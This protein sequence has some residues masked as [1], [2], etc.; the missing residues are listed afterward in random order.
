M[1][2]AKHPNILAVLAALLVLA[3]PFSSRAQFTFTT[4]NG[5]ITITGYTGSGGNVVIPSTTNGYPVTTIGIGAF[6]GK[7]TVTSVTIPNSVTS[8]GDHA[9]IDC[10]ILTNVTIGNGVSSIGPNAFYG[11]SSLTSVKIPNSV[12]S[13][14]D[15]A[16]A[17][18]S[19]LTS[20]TI[21]TNVN[22]IAAFAFVGCNGLT[23]V[24]IPNSIT[25]MG[26]YAFSDCSGLHQAYFQGNAPTVN[27]GEAGSTDSTIF[28]GES[29]MAYYLPGT[30]GWGS[31]FGGWP[32]AALNPAADFTYITNNGTIT[33]TGY[34][35]SGGNVVIPGTI[36]GYLVTSIDTGAFYNITTITNV[37]IPNSV[38]SIGLEA[39]FTCSSL[40]S[41]TIPDSVASI[42]DDAFGGCSG[43][44]S[45]TLG[46]SVTSI[47][48]GAFD[49]CL[50][51]TSV[52]IPNSVTSIGNAAFDYC[53]GLTSV[54]IPNSVT[55]IGDAPFGGC[56]SLTNIAVDAANP[57]YASVAGVL[58]NK[59][60]TLLIQYP[61]GLAGSYA[62]PNSVSS[63][64]GSAFFNCSSLTS[65]T[66]PNSVTSIGF[67]AF[68]YCSGLAS[69]TVGNSVT[70]IGN[71][72]F[73]SCTSL[74]R[75]Y[76]Q[77]NEPNVNG[78]PGSTDSTVFNGESGT[79][80]Y[81]PGTTGWG[82]TFGGWPTVALPSISIGSASVFED[83]SG[84]VAANF[85]I[86][87]NPTSPVP[88]TV[89]FA[90]ADGTATVADNDYVLT[91][92]VITFAPGE[93]NKTI[94]VFVNGDTKV[95]A[96]ETFFVTLS[97]PTN[98]TIGTAQTMGTI[99]NDDIQ[100]QPAWQSVTIPSL[101]VGCQ[102]GA[103][104][105]RT[106]S[107][108]YVWANLTNSPQSFLFRW[109]GANW[110]QVLTLTNHYPGKIFGTGPSDVFVSAHFYTNASGSSSFARVYRSTDNGTNW[111]E[112]TLPSAATN[113]SLGFGY[114]GGTENNVHLNIG[115]GDIL[116]FDGTN[117]NM[118]YSEPNRGVY[119]LTL[120]GTNEG[121]Y[122]TCNGWG[123]WNGTNWQSHSG[124][125][126]C[127]VYGG[128]W[129]LRDSGGKLSM[130]A[131]GQNNN[132]NGPHIWRFNETNST[133]SQVFSDGTSGNGIAIW[134]SAS[135]DVYVVGDLISGQ[136]DS[137]RIYHFDGTSWLQ[138]M[139]IGSIPRPGGV[140][141]TAADD[142][143]VSLGTAG[144]MLHYAPTAP[145][146]IQIFLATTNVLI[147]WPGSAI[148][149]RL[150]SAASLSSPVTWNPVT[151][152][153]NLVS[154][155]YQLTFPGTNGTQFFHLVNP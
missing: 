105:A 76:F 107:E 128:V 74:H 42:G 59:S 11:C 108:A 86:T 127:D 149:Y 114:F 34:I 155:L 113:E 121:Y 58:F 148:G 126:G 100:L 9:F 133:W 61:G 109:D 14:G 35:G 56:S 83:Q 67:G 2:H 24:M 139:N 111:S 62:V 51:L 47:G 48:N 141:G 71:Y 57:N 123:N 106:R 132:N 32:T 30:T 92:G 21:G 41:V 5:A 77:G 25:N 96:D 85:A 12:T 66:I 115:A 80:Y 138:I 20:A 69:V 112:Q 79:A 145:P 49:Y 154:N 31:T 136:T 147:T 153:P 94:T 134:G 137:G 72:V 50:G 27:G 82:S 103:V 23:S 91:N 68:E 38:T 101:P 44:T 118:I 6:N 4:N 28:S 84:T 39:F 43:L 65:V 116:R 53:S 16:F 142:V 15:S 37:T 81:M 135:N 88:V 140:G 26:E 95:E 8:I 63:I 102:L 17:F 45:V 125:I 97:N 89:N 64:A 18:C 151:N 78:S 10:S 73:G 60:L 119:G 150:E 1:N 130:Y 54:T 75:A 124:S 55:S 36:N 7:T 131:T 98:A 40:K 99:L 104:W 144:T 52:T 22:N 13:I 46:N 19:G 90:T 129:G 70:N 33:I 93:S 110:G 143:W 29:G 146:A 117:W 87:L 3:S 152:N 120:V 122:V